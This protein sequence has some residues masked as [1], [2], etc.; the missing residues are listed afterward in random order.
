[1]ERI[2]V[3]IGNY[4]GIVERIVVWIG[5]YPNRSC[6]ELPELNA[7]PEVARNSGVPVD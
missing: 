5:N 3:W 2:V 7:L 4:P 6:R 1:M